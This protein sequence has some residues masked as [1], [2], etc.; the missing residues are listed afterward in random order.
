[1]LVNFNLS[2]TQFRLSKRSWNFLNNKH[3]VRHSNIEDDKHF[4]EKI[5]CEN[6]SLEFLGNGAAGT[7]RHFPAP[8]SNADVSLRFPHSRQKPLRRRDLCPFSIWRFFSREQ[9][10][11]ECDWV[12]MLSVFVPSQSSCFFSVRANEFA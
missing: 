6:T 5:T 8:L 10:K 4:F 3:I 1:M 12:V 7:A 9:A 2:M 11:G